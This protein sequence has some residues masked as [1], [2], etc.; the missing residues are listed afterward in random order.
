MH[1]NAHTAPTISTGGAGEYRRLEA[2]HH[3]EKTSRMRSP[4]DA[5]TGSSRLIFTP[6]TIAFACLCEM[7][8]SLTRFIACLCRLQR[9]FTIGAAVV[10]VLFLTLP[11]LA[12]SYNDAGPPPNVTYTVLD[13]YAARARL[14]RMRL[15]R[16]LMMTMQGSQGSITISTWICIFSTGAVRLMTRTT[17]ALTF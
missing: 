15:G 7:S 17:I 12:L 9:L 1:E 3:P 11:L 4:H 5:A 8:V 2:L 13:R 16:G 6:R 10:L 14:A